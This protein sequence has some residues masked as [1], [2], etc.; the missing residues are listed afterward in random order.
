[1]TQLSRWYGPHHGP[2]IF[3]ISPLTPSQLQ[4]LLECNQEWQ[5]LTITNRAKTPLI[6][7]WK[8]AA[9]SKTK[10][11]S[12]GFS[13][14]G[15]GWPARR[16]YPTLTSRQAAQSGTEAKVCLSH[17]E[18][19]RD[20]QGS[21]NSTTGYWLAMSPKQLLG[22]CGASGLCQQTEELV[23]LSELRLYDSQNWEP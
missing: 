16:D 23:R 20:A 10:P 6:D 22:Q 18:P 9:D 12:K 21:L 11:S 19:H 8:P 1:M 14:G 2:A 3:R 5:H 13:T 15:K 4:S 17:G 7:Q